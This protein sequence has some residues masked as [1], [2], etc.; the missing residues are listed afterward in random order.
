M[1]LLL[2][3][4]LLSTSKAT[5]SYVLLVLGLLLLFIFMSNIV[6]GFIITLYYC[7]SSSLAFMN[8]AFIMNDVNYGY[9][10]IAL[11]SNGSSIY[12]LLLYCHLFRNIWFLAFSRYLSLWWSGYLLLLLSIAESFIGYTLPFKKYKSL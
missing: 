4:H 11:H 10:Y 1:V 8:K 7:P 6:S 9:L 2:Y 5:L 12:M 3:Y